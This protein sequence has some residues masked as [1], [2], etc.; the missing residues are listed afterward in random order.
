MA[1][2]KISEF[3]ATPANNTDI[4]SINIAEGC[5]PSGI[6]DAIRELMAQ[7]K[8]FQTGAV[9]D[10]FNGPVGATTAAA[11]AFTTIASTG[12]STSAAYF[13]RSI[14]PATESGIETAIVTTGNGANQRAGLF[15]VNNYASNSTTELIFK[16]NDTTGSAVERARIPASGGF[17]S[18]TTISVGNATPSTSGAGITFPATQ[19]ASSN[20]NTLDDYEEGTWTPNQGTGLTVVGTF[21]S[22]GIY[23]KIGR[24]VFLQGFV[25]GS[26]S[27]A[28]TNGNQISSNMPF[29]ST[30]TGSVVGFG[31]ATNGGGTISAT[32]DCGPNSTQF[33]GTPDILAT[34]TIYFSLTY[35]TS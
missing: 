4:D 20:A 8:D 31:S 15:A 10:S 3:S 34:G 23:A 28:L 13:H 21:S 18:V 26:T 6:N 14:A 17:Q 29:T 19:S 32:T 35:Q 16:S 27:V 5:A 1:K 11:G 7:L 25:S 33:A 2:T 9:G 24:M 30:S 22:S 12:A